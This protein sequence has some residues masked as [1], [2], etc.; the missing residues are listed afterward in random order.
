MTDPLTPWQRV[1]TALA[2]LATDPAGVK[3]LWLRARA[4][5]LRD[6]VTAALPLARR[7]HPGID[8]RGAGGYVIAPPSRHNSGDKHY[9][10][11][12]P[13]LALIEHLKRVAT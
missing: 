4:S 8:F 11:C 3:G 12:E 10:W 5:P 2:V 9:Q 1:E 7:I 13:P 6:L